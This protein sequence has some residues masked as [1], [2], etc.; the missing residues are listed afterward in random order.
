MNFIH[1]VFA[2]CVI[3][4]SAP[5][6]SAACSGKGVEVQVLGSGGPETQDKRAS[7]SYLV[8]LAGKARVLI[9]AGGG[10]KLR[11]GESGAQM[12]DLDAIVFTHLHADHSSDFAALIKSS[13]F[14]ERSRPLPVFGPPGNERFPPLTGFV[15]ALFGEKNGAFRYLNDY[16][17]PNEPGGY[18]LQAHDV[19]LRNQEIGKVF[20]NERLHLSAINVI[21]GAVPALAWRVDI[22]GKSVVFSGDTS[23]ENGNLE[24]LA[25]GADLLVAHNSVPEGAAGAVLELHMPPAVIGRIARDAQIKHLVLSHRML[26]TLGKETQT[27]AA[28]R[29]LYAGPLV[30]ADDLDCFT[31]Q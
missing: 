9:D 18:K 1:W 15:A 2:C 11:F 16:I 8:W 12:T 28:I 31:L 21:H 27:Q 14:E 10:A 26:R 29:K 5:V 6:F 22:A 19:E 25:Q 13:Y 23:G 3:F 7:S 4:L 24:L 30:F 20:S 17:N